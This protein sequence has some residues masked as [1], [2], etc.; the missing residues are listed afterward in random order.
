MTGFDQGALAPDRKMQYCKISGTCSR[1]TFNQF[2]GSFAA[3]DVPA[4][5]STI[6]TG[7]DQD[8]RLVFGV[9]EAGHALMNTIEHAMLDFLQSSRIDYA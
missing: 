9:L 6:S 8:V 1:P 3:A 4:T 2:E 5:D 7:S